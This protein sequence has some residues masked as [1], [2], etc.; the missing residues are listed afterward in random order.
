MGRIIIDE[1]DF[2]VAYGKL[3]AKTWHEET[4]GCKKILFIHGWMDN[5]GSF[6]N[7]APLL[8]HDDDLYI[9]S[10]DLPG[11]GK[12]SQIPPGSA[13][14]DTTIIMEMRRCLIELNW[15]TPK[16]ITDIG[17]CKASAGGNH[18][19]SEADST[20]KFT[21]IGHS[22][23]GGLGAFYSSLYPDE[24][25]ELI[26]LDFFK[27]ETESPER[28]LKK[29]ARSIDHFIETGSQG[30]I[31]NKTNDKGQVVVS[32]ETALVATIEAHKNLGNLTREEAACLLKRSTIP[33]STPPNSVIYNRDLRLQCM[34]NLREDWDLNRIMFSGL[35]CHVLFILVKNGIYDSSEFFVDHMDE[36]IEFY[37][38]KAKSFFLQWV[39]G[40][41]FAHMNNSQ[42]IANM[43]NS[44]LKSPTDYKV[45]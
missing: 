35:K 11:H 3:V 7:L 18:I 31:V 40:D 20:K 36:M 25:E 9:V 27:S 23:G 4:E 22:F 43:I 2:N 28:A 12:S 32:Q 5:S 14:S 21:I 8:K 29:L 1:I 37:K 19:G 45:V 41:H 30:S 10:I 39:D 24:V 33:V 44:Y 15:V 13:Y 34:L 42:T 6:D 17:G 38:S 26:L 16:K